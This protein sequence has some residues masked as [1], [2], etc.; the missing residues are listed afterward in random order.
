[1][2]PLASTAH[3]GGDP[4]VRTHRTRGSIEKSQRLGAADRDVS[5]VISLDPSQ[6]DDPDEA[7]VAA[8]R[9]G[10]DA[11][12][13][14][15]LGKYRC[16]ARAKAKS[17][18]I[19]GADADDIVQE[20]MIGLFKAIRDYNPQAQSSFRVFAELCVTRQVITAIKAATRHK[21]SP[22][23]N[24]VSLSRPVAADDEGDR[25]LADVLS[26]GRLSDPA[27]V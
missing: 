22:L 10:D 7:L 4:T 11:A 19:V 15:L 8:A 27:D 23:N 3:P 14:A 2:R 13:D 16:Y 1:M 12:L 9:A 25:C 24:Y 18:F 17:Y 26:A 5:L 6:G 20:G 21:H